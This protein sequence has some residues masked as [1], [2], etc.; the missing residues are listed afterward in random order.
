MH[1]FFFSMHS[2]FFFPFECSSMMF[3]QSWKTICSEFH[4]DMIAQITHFSG[5]N[6][7][8]T[9]TF[10]I[11]CKCMQFC[12]DVLML[13]CFRDKEREKMVSAIQMIFGVFHNTILI[14]SALSF[15]HSRSNKCNNVHFMSIASALCW[16][17]VQPRCWFSLLLLLLA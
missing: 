4:F 14:S 2:V 17:K 9:K 11:N 16:N 1:I 10:F 7:V 6:F 12:W 3:P 8:V 13:F 15:L 5:L